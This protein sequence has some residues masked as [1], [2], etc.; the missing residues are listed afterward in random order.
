LDTSEVLKPID[1]RE[2][3]EEMESNEE[4]R[5]SSAVLRAWLRAF[6]GSEAALAT[7]QRF[8]GA[9]RQPEVV[10]LG[11]GAAIPSKY[12]NGP[13]PPISPPSLAT[14]SMLTCACAMVCA[15]AVCACVCGAVSSVYVS[16]PSFGG[17]L[18]DAG[19]GSFGQLAR[20]FGT[21]R[22][23]RVV[24]ELQV[25]LISHM[26]ADH[27]LGLLRILAIRQE[28]IAAS[29][30]N[31]KQSETTAAEAEAEEEALVV[32]G[33]PALKEWLDEYSSQIERLAYRFVPCHALNQPQHPVRYLSRLH[34]AR[35]FGPMLT[36]RVA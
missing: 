24:A 31:S 4:L 32:V 25:V 6:E 15:C 5:E 28:L 16:V 30:R 26:H 33:P 34:A 21:E 1:E 36:C 20:R 22:A 29:R 14:S 19:E 3:A 27:H 7:R 12:R 2:V 8:G 18:M 35:S 10:F 13:S 11:T 23:L 17:L 9:D